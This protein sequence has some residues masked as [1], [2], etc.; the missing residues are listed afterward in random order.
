MPRRSELRTLIHKPIST[1]IDTR[2]PYVGR[3]NRPKCTNCGYTVGWMQKL[4]NLYLTQ[5]SREVSS[6]G[7][8]S[9]VLRTLICDAKMYRMKKPSVR[10]LRYAFKK[11]ERLLHQGEEV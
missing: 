8:D 9:G 3:K 10:D 7:R 2:K 11:A 4:A 5:C 6:S 1:P